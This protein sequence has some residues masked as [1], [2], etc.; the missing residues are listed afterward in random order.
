LAEVSLTLFD[1]L[2]EY[3][4][5]LEAKTI[6]PVSRVWS[7]S[8][9]ITFCQNW[10]NQFFSVEYEHQ[11]TGFSYGDARDAGACR[12]EPDHSQEARAVVAEYIKFC[13]D[14]PDIIGA[15]YGSSASASRTF[16]TKTLVRIV[17]RAHAWARAV[18]V[19]ALA[20]RIATSR[21]TYLNALK[22][23]GW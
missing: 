22:Q 18:P 4:G 7:S 10:F 17:E 5:E 3:S 8:I 20:A 16:H 1:L 2:D 11:I 9:A 14:Y 13:R 23:A 21:E 12:R 19:P 6:T 15:G